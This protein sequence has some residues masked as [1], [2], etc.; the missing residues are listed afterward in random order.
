M[1]LSE[2]S[3]YRNYIILG[4]LAVFTAFALWVRMIPS[5]GLVSVAGVNLLGND[6]WYNLRLIEVI[7]ENPLSYPWFDPMTYYP[8]GTD[9]F[10]GPMFP[11]IGA[12]MCLLSGASTRP[13]IMYVASWLPPLMGAVMVPLMYLVFVGHCLYSMAFYLIH[14]EF[15]LI[16]LR[17][18]WW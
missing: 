8:Y 18:L 11:I 12:V 9:N 17:L 6:P 15:S 3:K 1:N 4:L 5:E 2:F 16:K 7:V 14:F 10:W 13:E